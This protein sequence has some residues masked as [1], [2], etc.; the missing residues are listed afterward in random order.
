MNTT[1]KNM[2]A[3]RKVQNKLTAEGK[4]KIQSLLDGAFRQHR[5]KRVYNS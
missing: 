5:P 2:V 4:K 3:E 1:G